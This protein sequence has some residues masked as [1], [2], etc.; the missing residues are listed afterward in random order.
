[1]KK[2]F[3]I[4]FLLFSCTG[5]S[6]NK[7][8]QFIVDSLID[9]K[10]N[11]D[12]IFIIPGLGC[13]G[14][15]T[16]AERF[17]KENFNQPNVL[18]IFTSV[19]SMKIL[20][21][22]MG[23]KVLQSPNVVV[24]LENK[25]SVP[26]NIDESIYPCLVYLKGKNISGIK[27]ASPEDP[28]SLS[29]FFRYIIQN[30]ELEIDLSHPEEYV[31]NPALRLSDVANHIDY[32]L[33]KLP[34]KSPI[35]QIVSVRIADNEIFCLDKSCNLYVF[36][37]NGNFRTKIGNKG[38][39]PGEYISLN[40]FDIDTVLKEVYLLDTGG[41]K[42]LTYTSDGKYL[43]EIKLPGRAL[44]FVKL[45]SQK[46]MIYLPKYFQEENHSYPQLCIVDKEGSISKELSLE[47]NGPKMNVN[48]FSVPYMERSGSEIFFSFA[49][50]GR[51]Y[52]IFQDF[53]YETIE[54]VKIDQ[55]KYKLPSEISSNYNL[56]NKY[57]NKYIY[58]LSAQNFG[59]YI[60]L[61]FYFRGKAYKLV[62]NK[63]TH[64]IFTVSSD[65]KFIGLTDDIDHVIPFFPNS[66]YGRQAVQVVYG[67]EIKDLLE[68]NKIS[69]RISSLLDSLSFNDN[70]LV[71]R[72]VTLK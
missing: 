20:K 11:Y 56:Y 53:E 64:Q 62:F 7:H 65:K 34:D 39:G 40:K 23:D 69:S 55:G 67:Y 35:D 70:H 14:C 27:F 15:I 57:L 4:L 49:F 60:W 26:A 30:Q 12:A 5:S 43:Y 72:I 50:D 18:F 9:S 10:S 61:S 3:L 71:L 52:R 25:Y 45:S 58:Q 36:D 19:P 44:N 66:C 37:A 8:C 63:Y 33:L 59:K 1:M 29:A 28:G 38:R 32:V 42:I 54:Y 17:V 31:S 24:D 68:K 46:F 21:L 2:C 41:G 13:P 47:S 6:I 16:K 22:K 51:I 48:M